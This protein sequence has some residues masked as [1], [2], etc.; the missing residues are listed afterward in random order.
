MRLTLRFILSISAL[1]IATSANAQGTKL[2]KTAQQH[3]TGTPF[4][5]YYMMYDGYPFTIDNWTN[6]S[7][8]LI[9]GET[10]SEL[11]LKYD[12]LH[13]DVVY[14][15]SL[16]HSMISIDKDIITQFEL[17]YPNGTTETFKCLTGE[18]LGTNNGKYFAIIYEDSI[19]LVT[20][21]ITRIQ[22]NSNANPSSRKTGELL[23][24]EEN[25]IWDQQTLRSVP[26]SRSKLIN[27]YPQFK[28]ELRHFASKNHI[29][30][31]NKAD[32]AKMV[33]EINRLVADK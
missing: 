20:K 16:N 6:G 31:R 26:R 13:E 2:R 11:Q 27:L 24:R 15:N 10:Y 33:E 19:S 23:H 3:I 5:I 29:K 7:V 18:G 9:S 22:N 14:Y 1:V 8:T 25:Y 17:N 28:D 30:M 21:Y 12:A 4:N 32:V